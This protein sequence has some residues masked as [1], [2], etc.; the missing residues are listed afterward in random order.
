LTGNWTVTGN[1]NNIRYRHTASLLTDGKVLVAGGQ[2]NRDFSLDS[3]EIYDPS[4]G[5]WTTIGNLND[6]RDFHAA[7]VL[8][9]GK[10]LVI[11]GAIENVADLKSAELY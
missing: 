8:T 3:A 7:S 6:P 1:L 9:N 11:G 4:T 10:V 5:N 2:N